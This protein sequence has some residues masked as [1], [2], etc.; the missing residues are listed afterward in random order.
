MTEANE[1]KIAGLTVVEILGMG[2]IGI[3]YKVR[4]CDDKI[5]FLKVIKWDYIRDEDKLQQEFSLMKMRQLNHP[6]IA[7]LFDIGCTTAGKIWFTRELLDSPDPEKQPTLKTV[8]PEMDETSTNLIILQI[9]DA[10][11][12]LHRNGLI[13]GNLKLSNI[14]LSKNDAKIKSLWKGH[15]TQKAPYNTILTEATLIPP[16]GEVENNSL[17]P[18][19]PLAT[20]DIKVFGKI[21]YDIYIDSE[22][23]NGDFSLSKIREKIPQSLQDIV[24]RMIGISREPKFRSC[25]E[26]IQSMNSIQPERAVSLDLK[27]IQKNVLISKDMERKNFL[28]D[29]QID[30]EQGKG[31]FVFLEGEDGSG[32]TALIRDFTREQIDTGKSISIVSNL[33]Y[34]HPADC[35]IR[36]LDDISI[37]LEK[38]NPALFSHYN[39]VNSRIKGE[40]IP[41]EGLTVSDQYILFEG[42]VNF[43]RELSQIQ[44]F[45][46]VIEDI[47]HSS[48]YMLNFLSM[49]LADIS[50]SRILVVA[51]ISPSRIR[52]SQQKLFDDL[53][54]SEQVSKIQVKPL[55]YSN[56]VTHIRYLTTAPDLPEDIC[57]RFF[58]AT[59]GNLLKLDELV[60]LSVLNGALSINED[61]YDFNISKF[62]ELSDNIDVN[63][64]VPKIISN[65]SSSERSIYQ[66]TAMMGGRITIGLLEKIVSKPDLVSFENRSDLAKTISEL[67]SKGFLRKRIEAGGFYFF[68]SHKSFVDSII[69]MIPTEE[70]RRIYDQIVSALD[71]DE[72]R[73]CM[74]EPDIQLALLATKGN[75][76]EPA[77]VH[78]IRAQ[79]ACERRL[80]YDERKFFLIKLLQMIPEENRSYSNDCRIKLVHTLYRQGDY[81]SV[82]K[83]LPRIKEMNPS[84]E[85]LLAIIAKKVDG[86][87]EEIHLDRSVRQME[88][89]HDPNLR[90]LLFEHYLD[91]MQKSDPKKTLEYAKNCIAS[92]Q[93]TPDRIACY[94]T[95]SRL[96]AA[97]ADFDGSMELANE[98]L[99]VA[100]GMEY[101]SDKLRISI[102]IIK[103]TQMMGRKTQTSRTIRRTEGMVSSSWDLHLKSQFYWLSSRFYIEN[104]DTVSALKHLSKLVSVESKLKLKKPLARALLEYGIMLE[105]RG[106]ADRSREVIERARYMAEEINDN[107]TLAKSMILIGTRHLENNS[108]DQAQVLLDRASKL[109][110]EMGEEEYVAQVEENLGRISLIK[111][112]LENARLHANSLEQLASSTKNETLHA[113]SYR[114][115]ATIYAKMGKYDKAEEYYL[116]ALKILEKKKSKWLVNSIKID[117]AELFIKQEDFFRASS[118]LS[119]AGMFFDEEGGDKELKRIRRAEF[120]IDKELG[121]YGEDYRNLRMLLEISRALVQVTNLN[122]L[123]PMIVDMALKVS[124]AERGFIMLITKSGSLDFRFGRN[125]EKENLSPDRFAFSSSVTDDVISKGELVSVTDTESDMKFKSKDSIVGLSLRS[126]MAAPL[127]MGEKIIGIVYVD[128]Q[129]PTF[130]F[131]KKN[132]EF[133]KALCSHAATAISFAELYQKNSQ[134]DSLIEENKAL[135]NLIKIGKSSNKRHFYDLVNS[136]TSMETNLKKTLGKSLGGLDV[137]DELRSLKDDITQLVDIIDQFKK[138]VHN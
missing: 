12:Y 91:Y 108:I 128:S 22:N 64:L 116:K 25:A 97:M 95:A 84:E 15:Q 53:L 47:E 51:S 138:E 18:V 61:S 111:D 112:N 131:S 11:D 103:L 100:K 113:K 28:L 114:L 79:S 87:D 31:R 96:S 59:G 16:M 126:I 35:I 14:L 115:N 134:Y 106:N 24:A 65:L 66:F 32:K 42:V 109:L 26:V 132:A 125:K 71:D 99:S 129:I 20:D 88:S 2:E 54:Y 5:V 69:S 44:P 41:D 123:L 37:L 136:A 60:R 30:V 6:N 92:T 48:N 107:H 137:S 58:E 78:T 34:H 50:E 56:S 133:F 63:R 7:Q 43:L 94:L 83:Y 124:G 46:L 104:E 36:L 70:R 45:C 127:K 68:I 89:I 135:K 17:F 4:D 3:S 9:L 55:D 82:Q 81:Q 67:I 85:A 110:G 40:K 38:K 10:L 1:L 57:A 19:Y 13:H 93:H 27:R 117:L 62:T 29:T 23:Q 121:K 90:R 118:K 122:E 76:P 33:D 98:A 119:E 52:S 73:K 74:P 77:F 86:L 80:A 8:L 75:K 39:K 120:H 130:Y 101:A 49:L 102:W 72:A 105:R 21:L